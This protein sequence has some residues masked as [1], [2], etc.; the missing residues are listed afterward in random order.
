[1]TL[2]GGGPAGVARPEYCPTLGQAEE[3][4]W[5][6]EKPGGQQTLSPLSVQKQHH[7]HPL[8][9]FFYMT[10]VSEAIPNMVYNIG[11]DLV[12][13]TV[14]IICQNCHTIFV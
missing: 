2:P 8:K 9:D 1:M 13:S 6:E 7:T 3:V 10:V 12:I 11:K 14:C 4:A 5:Q